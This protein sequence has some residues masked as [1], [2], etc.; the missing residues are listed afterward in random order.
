MGNNI[1]VDEQNNTVTLKSGHTAITLDKANGL[2]SSIQ[3]GGNTF[4]LTNGPRFTSGNLKLSEVRTIQEDNIPVYEFIY[5]PEGGEPKRSTRNVMRISLLPSD[6][7]AIDYSFDRGGRH[8][9]IGITFDI[10]ENDVQSVKWLGNGPYRVWKNRLKGVTFGIWEKDYNN[11]ITGESWIYPEFKGFHS[12][13]YAADIH[14]SHGTLKI[15][16]ASEDLFLHLLTPQPP[17]QS[18]NTN[19]LAPFP[20]G[21]LSIL[22]AISP[23]GTKFMK[24]TEHGPQGQPNQFVSAGHVMPLK[25]KVFLRIE[26]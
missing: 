24:S 5:R 4:P 17:V 19:T 18:R 22:N 12:N 16:A 2:I 21:N 11:T 13:L 7:I 15:V 14:T 23:V 8:D 26:N 20:D 10:P 25:G 1:A 3:T 9:H 6:W